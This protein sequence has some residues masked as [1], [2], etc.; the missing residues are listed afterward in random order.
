MNFEIILIVQPSLWGRVAVNF[1]NMFLPQRFV[2]SL[3]QIIW[4]TEKNK[5]LFIEQD[6]TTY[7]IGSRHLPQRH[8][9]SSAQ[10]QAGSTQRSVSG[11]NES[12]AITLYRSAISFRK[13]WR[14]CDI[15]LKHLCIKVIIHYITIF[16]VIYRSLRYHSNR[17]SFA[18]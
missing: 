15:L 13:I 11:R 2:V 10:K 6:Y 16:S 8:V 17:L 18:I 3:L 5:G 1:W 4:Q 9:C 7:L 14:V 12:Y